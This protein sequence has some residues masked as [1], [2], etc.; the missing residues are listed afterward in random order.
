MAVRREALAYAMRRAVTDNVNQSK[1][2]SDPAR[3][4]PEFG[5]CSYVAQYAAIKIRWS[6]RVDAT[7]KRA[8]KAV[9]S[10][11]RNVM[12]RVHKAR[13]VTGRGGSGTDPRFDTCAEAIAHGY[14]PYRRGRDPEYAWYTDADDDGWVCES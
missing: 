13:V 4:L 8:M 12:I 11:C 14:G 5:H 2:D 9:A 6:L 10:H 1:G 3:W 7:E